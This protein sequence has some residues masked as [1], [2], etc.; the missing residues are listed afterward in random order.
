MIFFIFLTF[1]IVSFFFIAKYKKLNKKR[2][3]K[4][5]KFKKKLSCKESKIEKI[6]LRQDEKTFLD[7]NINIQI[8]INDNEE[9]ILK[10]VN[11]H[12]ARLAKYKKSKLNGEFL[13][14]DSESNIYKL[15]KGKKEI[16]K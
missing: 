5:L 8:D 2:N 4:L 16:I 13:F 10:K 14:Q 12:R 11:I 15:V 3:I 6:F 1:L 9:N 7:P